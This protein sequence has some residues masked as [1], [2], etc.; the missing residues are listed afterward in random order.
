MFHLA[1]NNTV[2]HDEEQIKTEALEVAENWNDAWN[3][4]ID[5]DRMMSLHHEDLQYY[6][7]GKPMTYNGFE[8]VL[9]KYV[10]GVET[11]N[12]KLVNPV[13]TVIDRNNAVIGFQLADSNEDTDAID[14]SFSLVITRVDSAWKIIHIHEG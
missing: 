11:Y 9:R 2:A 12:N 5:I 4:V 6:W 1:C 10:I 13:V 7:H 3:G 8:E 14:T